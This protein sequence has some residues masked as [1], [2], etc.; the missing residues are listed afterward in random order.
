MAKARH[1]KS[2]E[3]VAPSVDPLVASRFP[4]D[5]LVTFYDF[6]PI[7]QAAAARRSNRC[8]GCRNDQ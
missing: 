7:N 6:V 4:I 2:P 5:R 1:K 8:C 3:I